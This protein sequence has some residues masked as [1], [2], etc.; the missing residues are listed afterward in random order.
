[1]ILGEATYIDV[2]LPLPLKQKFTY[3]LGDEHLS[4]ITIGVRVAV[5]FGKSKVYAGIVDSIHNTKPDYEV[6][7]IIDVLDE[8]PIV[9]PIHLRLWEW[10]ADYYMCSLGEVMNAA[11]PSSFKLANETAIVIHP[12]WDEDTSKLSDAE[13]LIMDALLLQKKLKIQEIAQILQRKTILPFIKKMQELKLIEIEEEIKER[14]RPKIRKMMRLSAGLDPQQAIAILENHRRSPKQEEFLKQYLA[15]TTREVPF[16][17]FCKNYGFNNSLIKGLVSKD[18]LELY[19]LEINRLQQTEIEGAPLAELNPEQGKVLLELRETTKQVNLLHG[20]TSSGKTEVY[21]HLIKEVIDRGEQVLFLVPEIA[22]TIQLVSRLK[23][24]FGDLVGVFHSKFGMNE[25]VEL[26]RD[27]KNNLRFPIIIGARS[28]VFLP[29]E[30]L[31]LIIVDEEHE[32]SFKQQDPAPRYQARD[33]AVYMGHHYNT[34]VL[35]GTATPSLETAYNVHKGKYGIHSLRKRYGGF[36]FPTIHRVDIAHAYK[37]KRMNG[38]FSEALLTSIQETLDR[39]EQVLLFQNRRGFA[40]QQ[41][42]QSCGHVPQCKHCDVSLTY[43]K[44][45]RSIRCHY[46]GYSE[47]TSTACKVCKKQDVKLKGFGTEKIEDELLALF[48]GRIIK[49][50][51]LD[52]T[53]KKNSYEE[54][55]NAFE[56]QEI[57][58]LVG[59][60]MI[61]K[62]LDF[63]SV[64][65]VGVLS[66]DQMLNFPDFRAFE[67]AF[68]MLCQVSGRAGRKKLDSEVIIQT[69]QPDHEVLKLVENHNYKDLLKGQLLERQA[70]RYPPYHRLIH[71]T[72]RNRNRRVL[73]QA[74]SL[75]AKSMRTVFEYR[76][77]GP[78]Y[79]AIERL[80]GYYQKQILLKIERKLSYPDA[81]DKLNKFVNAVLSQQNFRGTKIKVDVDPF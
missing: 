70:F 21:I 67:R 75:L 62:G 27:V 32:S 77:L 78:E 79:P 64:G 52:T 53:R 40:P 63:N 36:S 80:K 31:G 55:L 26:W 68:Q 69:F 6:K 29:F 5:P 60:Q 23:H 51:D 41:E 73:E 72:V 61:S 58:I 39:G 28:S 15:E 45:S 44:S 54:I 71:I 11:L 30:N 33:V 38:H 35:L 49:R 42:C 16:H 22:L 46:C 66:A 12:N 20:V 8:L 56:E 14:F 17:S 74:S 7:F 3:Q 47:R 10:I 48:P 24:A 4:L 57:D 1:M 37:R 18:I 2:I 9:A 13:F 65:L 81:K 19:D 34:K 76:V 50:M 43:H 25:R 59:T